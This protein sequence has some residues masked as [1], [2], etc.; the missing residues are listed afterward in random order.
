[1]NDKTTT[2]RVPDA[3]E[4]FDKKLVAYKQRTKTHT[5]AIKKHLT[6]FI[7]RTLSPPDDVSVTTAARA[8]L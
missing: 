2:Q 3:G 1:M 4:D 5:A 8:W 7:S 6:Q